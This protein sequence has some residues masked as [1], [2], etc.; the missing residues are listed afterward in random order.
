MAKP[1]RLSGQHQDR[2]T[3]FAQLGLGTKLV[4]CAGIRNLPLHPSPGLKRAPRLGKTRGSQQDRPQV[5]ESNQPPPI[6]QLLV[7]LLCPLQKPSLLGLQQQDIGWTHF[8]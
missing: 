4:R 5:A 1:K 7:D 2:G 3:E 6:S 8:F